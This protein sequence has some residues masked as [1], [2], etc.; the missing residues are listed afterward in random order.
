M[1]KFLIMETNLEEACRLCLTTEKK[2]SSIFQLPASDVP[3]IVKIKACLSIQ[4]SETDPISTFICASCIENV[5]HWYFYKESCLKSQNQL[6]EWFKKRNISKASADS[7]PLENNEVDDENTNKFEGEI[8]K[9]H[10]DEPTIKS[11]VP[12]NCLPNN[13]EIK[14]E[15]MDSSDDYFNDDESINDQELL[16]NP[17]SPEKNKAEAIA[18]KK[19]GG[20]KNSLKRRMRKRGHT[21]FR[22]IKVFKKKCPHCHLYL[23]SKYSYYQHI[24]NTH[25]QLKTGP[26]QQSKANELLKNAKSVS[27][28]IPQNEINTEQISYQKLLKTD[29]LT[30][31]QK[32]IISQLK[33]FS[34]YSCDSIFENRKDTLT[35]IRIHH[36]DLKLFTCI[37]CL[38]EFPDKT[39]YKL[40]C[41]ASFECAMKIAL[42]IPEVGTEKYFT[43]NMCLL[44]LENRKC[45]LNHLSKHSEK[46]SK[47][48]SRSTPL[49]SLISIS[50]PS[51][52]KCVSKV[53]ISSQAGP[54][55]D[56]DPN[57][58]HECNMCGMIYRYKPNLMKH[59]IVCLTLPENLRSTFKCIHCCMTFRVFDKFKSHI[60]R[61]HKKHEMICYN[62][63]ES[64][65]AD[66]DYLNHH[67]IHRV[68]IKNEEQEQNDV[69]NINSSNSS[70]NFNIKPF[71]CALCG[72]SFDQKIELTE[73]RNLHLKVKLYSCVLCG[74]SF[75]NSSALETHMKN[76]GIID[77]ETHN[78]IQQ[79][80]ESNA[81]HKSIIYAGS[82]NSGNRLNQCNECGRCFSNTANLN[83]HI[84]NLHVL[85]KKQWD[86]DHCRSKFYSAEDY[87]DHLRSEHGQNTTVQIVENTATSDR[88]SILSSGTGKPNMKCPH[89]ERIFA[90]QANLAQHCQK[91]HNVII[92][93]FRSLIHVAR[94]PPP[95]IQQPPVRSVTVRHSA[96]AKPVNSGWPCDLCDRVFKEEQSMKTHR[97]WHMR[98][99]SHLPMINRNINK[100]SSL[101]TLPSSTTL[102]PLKRV[103]YTTVSV[104]PEPRPAKARKSFINNP[105]R[106]Q[107]DVIAS[108][109]LSTKAPSETQDTSLSTSSDIQCQVCKESFPNLDVLSR[110]LWDVHCSLNKPDK[111]S[112]SEMQCLLCSNKFPD[113]ESLNEHMLQHTTEPS[114]NSSI[115]DEHLKSDKS[116]CFHCDICGKNYTN[117]KVFFRHKKMHK[118][119][120]PNA[121][122]FQSLNTKRPYCHPCQKAFS[123]DASLRRHKISA[124]HHNYIK[125]HIVTP[126]KL[127]TTAIVHQTSHDS[128]I[129]QIKTEPDMDEYMEE[130][131]PTKKKQYTCLTCNVTFPNMSILYQHKQRMHKV[132]EK[133][134]VI[135]GVSSQQVKSPARPLYVAVK[136]QKQNGLVDCNLCGK[137]FPGISNLKL[138]YAHKHKSEGKTFA[139]TSAGCKQS[140]TSISLL[141]AHET[142]HSSIMYNCR[143][144]ERHVF[145]RS[146]IIKHMLIAHKALYKSG[147]NTNSLWSTVDLSA[148]TIKNC[149]GTFCTICR[150]KYP[151]L[152]ALKI[153]YL[154]IHE[155]NN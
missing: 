110:H 103:G 22:G 69:T 106:K 73:H 143:L 119:L 60:F 9:D 23:N 27:S 5:N 122:N 135:G 118:A 49:P 12:N 75:N 41:A 124:C 62:C 15:P 104:S 53:Y 14:S 136:N 29:P 45:L 88:V 11:N 117:R 98:E 42:V 28:S 32:K 61:Y 86:C 128:Q 120:P 64:Y 51:K 24:N 155:Q 91:I 44:S 68:P 101:V 141:K 102:T 26:E 108:S 92:H 83:R 33:T 67:E 80:N 56:G 36:P 137:Q 6:Q 127:T 57:H 76:H 30:H 21:H 109:T 146:A 148:Y 96:P 129:Q 130:D 90:Y 48:F 99:N 116:N 126:K 139:C 150:V 74:N 149:Q 3:F 35:H 111:T 145:S 121:A 151:N 125:S 47:Q 113:N 39:Q 105:Q 115:A 114:Q 144:C 50:S 38:S 152:R 59:K 97:G 10:N 1:T 93:D 8:S 140:F 131:N 2:C 40:H 94:S 154:K 77:G 52:N 43:C 95:P 138:H 81:E 63:H 107:L 134:Q 153:H 71:K 87:N 37:A 142:M 100:R 123:N 20:I 54:Y 65:T 58:N 89:C 72:E 46:S 70:G 18:S 34:C 132:P 4:V 133:E 25:R 78:A 7:D 79:L 147:A 31:D 19:E 66:V 17:L 84:T 13:P 82:G 85:K 16:V 112:T 55:V